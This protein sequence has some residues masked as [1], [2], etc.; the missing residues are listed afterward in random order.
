MARTWYRNQALSR[1][2]TT[3]TTYSDVVSLTFT[4]A[5]ST[6]YYLLWSAI[7]D[8]SVTTDNNRHRL[9]DDTAGANLANP[10]HRSQNTSEKMSVGGIAKWTSGG[11]PGSQT[12]SIEHLSEVSGTVTGTSDAQMIAIRKETGDEY[13]ESTSTSS[14]T[15]ST[16]SDKTTLTFTP[17]SAGDYL[18]LVSA[19]LSGFISSSPFHARGRCLLDVGGTQYLDTVDGYMALT[20]SQFASW[21]GAAVVD[22]GASAQTLKIR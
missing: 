10:N 4:P 21:A 1:Q 8:S 14:T 12:F 17:A 15:S 7:F 20:A 3:S 5:P 19:E 16:L 11:A 13:A 6:D 18:I 22:Q 9:R 2:T